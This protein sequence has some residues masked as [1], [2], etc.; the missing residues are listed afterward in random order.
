MRWY[1]DN[2]ELYGVR[3]AE[4][5]DILLFGGVVVSADAERGLQNAIERVKSRFCPA[6]APVK[7]NFK[8][9]KAFYARYKSE[10]LYKEMLDA[11]REIR[12]AIFEAAA[13][14]DFQIV[15]S[16]IE[17]H[18]VTRNVIKGKKSALSGFAFSNGLMRFGLC[19]QHANP[20]PLHAQVVL[21]W[22]EKGD[23]EPFSREYTSAYLHGKSSTSTP[24]FCGPLSGHGFLDSVMFTTMT[25]CT[26]LQFADLVLGATREV[27]DCALGKR[28]EAFGLDM[29]RVVKGKFHGAP[30]HL[31]GRGINVPSGNTRLRTCLRDYLAQTF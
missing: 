28:Q 29:A 18:S 23:T 9:L 22:P 30:A 5:P 1:A 8:D 15:V 24:Y 3:D 13:Q 2:S 7:W 14:H 6:R 21:D 31:F 16:C 10:A 27:V 17:S 20:K 26:L 25:H 4:I 19:V 12:A 11:S